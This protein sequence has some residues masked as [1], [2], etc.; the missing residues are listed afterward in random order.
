MFRKANKNFLVHGFSEWVDWWGN[1]ITGQSHRKQ[2]IDHSKKNNLWK[3]LP[4]S[5]QR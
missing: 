2:L 4:G 3:T 5:P 1:V